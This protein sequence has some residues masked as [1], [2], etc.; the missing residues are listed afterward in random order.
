MA[1]PIFGFPQ[2]VVDQQPR[3]RDYKFNE[4]VAMLDALLTGIGG[5]SSLVN[6]GALAG[7]GIVVKTG[8]DTW[9]VRTITGEATQFSISNGT[10]VAGNPFLAL[11]ASPRLIGTG[12]GTANTTFLQFYES[13]NSTRQGWVGFGS[14]TDANLYITTESGMGNLIFRSQGTN[15]CQVG[16]AALAPMTSGGLELGLTGLR[17]TECWITV[18][19]QTPSLINSFTFCSSALRYARV[20]QTV[21]VYGQVNRTAVPG[22][23]TTIFTLPAGFRPPRN[24]M[25]VG[26]LFGAGNNHR[27][28]FSITITSGGAVQATWTAGGDTGAV[29]TANFT[30][31]MGFSFVAL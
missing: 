13:N 8:A 11:V 15:R 16:T 9:A 21:H 14:N 3:G 29:P 2:I 27:Q 4:L 26:E 28:P 12:T 10:G 6:L 18:S 1:T 25:F 19:E 22:V 30:W 24:I 5:N 23:G 7:T 31:S 20:A 17:W